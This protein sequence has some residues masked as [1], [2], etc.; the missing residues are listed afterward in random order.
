MLFGHCKA[1]FWLFYSFVLI[2]LQGKQVSFLTSLFHLEY[3]FSIKKTEL[4]LFC[5][6]FK[7][8]TDIFWLLVA[9]G[10]TGGLDSQKAKEVHKA[11]SQLLEH[12][13][14]RLQLLHDH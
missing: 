8:I 11:V 7:N 9:K 14:G 6:I 1:V 3:T 4:S 2:K 12:K 10:N 13:I 5:V